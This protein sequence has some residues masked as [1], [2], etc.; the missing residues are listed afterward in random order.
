MDVIVTTGTL[1]LQ[2]SHFPFGPKSLLITVFL[3]L[4]NAGV[5]RILRLSAETYG[6][7]KH[8]AFTC[9]S[10]KHSNIL[11]LTRSQRISGYNNSFAFLP[12]ST[13]PFVQIGLIP[14]PIKLAY[15]ILVIWLTSGTT[16]QFIF[17]LR[18]SVFFFNRLILNVLFF[19]RLILNIWSPVQRY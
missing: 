13:P 18:A 1:T 7:E 16:V 6:A 12:H 17:A 11:P 2:D 8:L 15:T 19:Y 10:E 9:Y 5:L 14:N 4:W 3:A